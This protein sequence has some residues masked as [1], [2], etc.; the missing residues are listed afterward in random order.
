MR[1]FGG[2]HKRLA[3]ALF[4]SGDLVGAFH[5]LQGEKGRRIVDLLAFRAAQSDAFEDNVPTA[6]EVMAML[7]RFN[8]PGHSVLV[9][10]AVY[11]DGV[12]A[13]VL[14]EKGIKAV[15]VAGD[16][17][18]L[19]ASQGADV[20][21]RERQIADLCMHNDLLRDLAKKVMAVVPKKA[22]L[23]IA[24]DDFLHN[25]PLHIIPVNDKAWC[26]QVAIGFIPAAGMLKFSPADN[27]R[28]GRCLVAGDSRGDLPYANAEC[29]YVAA[30]VNTRPLLGLECT[31]SAVEAALQQ[32]D[33]D[34][35]HLAVHGRGDVRR[36]GR[37]SL[38]LADG[39]GGTEWVLFEEL[40]QLEWQAELVVLSGCSTGVS[41]P[42]HGHEMVGAA[43][44]AVEAGASCVVASLWPVGDEVAFYLM[45]Q[46][47][48]EFLKKRNT[49]A[50]DVRVVMDHARESL[51][52][53]LAE[54][55]RAYASRR[56]GGST[57]PSDQVLSANQEA[58]LSWA[59]F[60]VMGDPI[61]GR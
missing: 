5:A 39:T 7:R 57:V 26:Q 16:T 40:C 6:V 8:M 51:R 28:T 18:E 49:G 38:L 48:D 61:V 14:S 31:R 24:P 55:L 2:L 17:N 30:A 13:Y 27:S 29:V 1:Q 45:R 43:R 42:V 32:G 53:A 59:P 46:F 9:D 25:F 35:V 23:L 15:F 10:C 50:V 11:E 12:S 19:T 22:R 21:E 47:Y 60:V 54:H 52:R 36:G 33:F 20:R 37:G 4:E 41:G 56:D 44:A 58:L 34:I 3:R